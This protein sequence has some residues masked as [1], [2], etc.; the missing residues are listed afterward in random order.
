MPS[1][2]TYRN[3]YVLNLNTGQIQSAGVT[4]AITDGAT[5]NVFTSTGGGSSNIDGDQSVTISGSSAGNG[6]FANENQAGLATITAN[7]VSLR[8]A[9]SIYES[10]GVNY[11]F[12]VPTS[13]TGAFTAGSTWTASNVTTGGFNYSNLP[14]QGADTVVLD[15]AGPRTVNTGSGNDTVTGSN[16]ADTIFGGAGNDSLSG[17][18]G[19]DRIAGDAGNDSLSGGDGSDT[20]WGGIG[21]DTI[22][23][24]NAADTLYGGAGTD[25]I[26][27]GEGNDLIEGDGTATPRLSFKWSQ[28]ADPNNGGA[29]G[30]DDGDI[31]ATADQ[32]GF[33]TQDT[34]GI[35]VSL[36][37]DE[38]T[39]G[40]FV[41][42]DSR[43]Q[44]VTGID[45]GGTGAVNANSSGA[46]DGTRAS[47]DPDND[48]STLTVRFSSTDGNYSG[49][50]TNVQFRVNDI[51]RNTADAAGFI[52]RIIIRAYDASGTRIAA[53][54]T[55]G[56]GGT[57]G[58]ALSD[59]AGDGYTGVDQATGNQG[60]DP[61]DPQGSILVTVGGPVA[62]I[63]IDYDNLQVGNQ[64]VTISDIYFTPV[65]TGAGGADSIDGGAG[66]DTILGQEGNDTI[67]GGTG[68]DS[69]D[70]GIG[71]DSIDGGAD[72]DTILGGTGNDTILGGAGNDSID[73]GADN[74][75]VDGGADNDTILG[76]AGNDT[77][78]GNT[79][80]DSIDGGTGNDSIAGGDGADTILGGA[81]LDTIQGGAGNDSIDGGADADV[82][83]GNAGA[84]T[85]QG[86]TGND[87]IRGGEGSDSIEGGEGDDL[88]LG[89]DTQPAVCFEFYNGNFAGSVDNI[90]ETGATAT[91]TVSNFDV[92]ALAAQYATSVSG[93]DPSDFGVRFTG[94]ITIGTGGSYTFFTNSDDGSK[95][96]ITDETGVERE[97][98]NNDGLHADQERSGTIDLPPGSYR[99]RVEFFERAGQEILGV[100]VQGPGIAKQDLFSAGLVSSTA[101]KGDDTISGGAGN[102]TLDGGFGT[103]T[104]TGGEGFDTFIADG[105]PDLIT[106]FNTATGQ[107]IRDGNQANNDF[108]D[109]SDFYNPDTLATYN[110]A[111]G[112]DF[113]QAISALRDDAADGVL[114]FAGGLRLT[115]VAPDDLT[116]DN[117]NVICF[118]P[119]TR[120]S[121]PLGPRAV[122]DLA[123][124]DL[125]ITRDHGIRPLVWTGRRDLSLAEV[126]AQP[127]LAP[128]LIRRDAFGPG[129]PGRD[130]MVSPQ[131]RILVN[132]ARLALATGAGEALAPAVALVDGVRVL[133]STPRAVS[134][135]HVMCEG[136]EV[137]RADGLWAETLLP[138]SEA[139]KALSAEA[140]AEIAA[141]FPD[142]E[143]VAPAHRLLAAT[144][145]RWLRAAG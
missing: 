9:Y 83:D 10:G 136:H 96:W 57:A 131:H 22:S 13:G 115:G 100:N 48:T 130:M 20:I 12:F 89:D 69:I 107:N 62:R 56:A 29:D 67:L 38:Q 140:C 45:T 77:L 53:T 68:A 118:T 113:T 50:V 39:S 141:I 33:V 142:L 101:G 41:D 125:V 36:D 74:D 44:N 3:A 124:G 81:G 126:T 4:V 16:Q 46:L 129:L 79:G 120:I 99:F 109:L 75:S 92:D 26:T 76:G 144:E 114:D 63:E 80:N 139:M 103:D 70:G 104:L 95:L 127:K 138:A 111:N 15:A 105:S 2:Y 1:T 49:S 59:R 25:T 47:G 72:N 88:L 137:I 54:L 14:A 37:Y 40:N 122:E 21:N 135:L 27:G 7:G 55:S 8:G 18:G 66:N 19:N 78:L 71:N 24:G 90:P 87:T 102:D 134:Y 58:P 128:I 34:G 85:I 23:G 84:D 94:E 51:D 97:V 11:A 31:L 32:T 108:V 52:D 145:A 98:V 110:D 28:I 5:D 17:Q 119:G 60:S 73:A 123:A 86:G 64:I 121:T 61:V 132:G 117:T 65:A 42:F 6:T 35:L 43:T 93:G 133:R 116:F 106:D 143:R 82:I 30:I 91:G 112:T